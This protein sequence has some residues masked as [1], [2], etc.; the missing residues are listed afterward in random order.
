MWS[1]VSKK[2]RSLRTRSDH[3]IKLNAVIMA[4]AVAT[5]TVP[6]SGIKSAQDGHS[7]RFATARI[8]RRGSNSAETPTMRGERTNWTL[9]PVLETLAGMIAT[10]P[11]AADPKI[12]STAIRALHPASP[13]A[14]PP[15]PGAV[16]RA[17]SDAGWGRCR[18]GSERW[19]RSAEPDRC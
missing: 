5:I 19:S 13:V 4:V 8:K 11:S 16:V 18:T 7:P 3:Q 12:W 17:P 10:V 2:G 1:A 14:S 15:A 9:W 6:M